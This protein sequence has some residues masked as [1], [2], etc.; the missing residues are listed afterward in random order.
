M[1]QL[2][3]RPVATMPL[4]TFENKAVVHALQENLL[5]QKASL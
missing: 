5:I 4:V 3:I 2:F 1:L